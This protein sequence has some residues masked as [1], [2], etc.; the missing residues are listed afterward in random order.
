MAPADC[1]HWAEN[2]SSWKISHYP[3]SPFKDGPVNTAPPAFTYGAEFTGGVLSPTWMVL[4]LRH[5]RHRDNRLPQNPQRL[6]DTRRGDGVLMLLLSSSFKSPKYTHCPCWMN[7]LNKSEDVRRK[8]KEEKKLPSLRQ[9]KF[10]FLIAEREREREWEHT[11]TKEAQVYKGSLVG[12]C[13]HA[14]RAVKC[15]TGEQTFQLVVW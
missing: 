5:A 4:C 11:F 1:F 9:K 6:T 3:D 14:F 8:G 2:R 15:C 13:T 10:I 12:M 7:K